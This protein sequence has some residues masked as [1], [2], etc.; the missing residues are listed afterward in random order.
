MLSQRHM[1]SDR[2]RPPEIKLCLPHVYS[3]GS[4]PSKTCIHTHAHIKSLLRPPSC[5]RISLCTLRCDIYSFK[6]VIIKITKDILYRSMHQKKKSHINEKWSRGQIRENIFGETEVK[7]AYTNCIKKL[8]KSRVNLKNI[9]AI[10][11]VR[12]VRKIWD[13]FE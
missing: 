4:T 13:P 6:F 12:S 3:K 9:R 8:H 5:F 7:C 1:R 2:G 11:D 10:M